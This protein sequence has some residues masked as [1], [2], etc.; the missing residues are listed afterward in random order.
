MPLADHRPQA[1]QAKIPPGAVHL[2]T[3]HRALAETVLMSLA[4]LEAADQFCQIKSVFCHGAPHLGRVGSNLEKVLM[5]CRFTYPNVGFSS[6]YHSFRTFSAMSSV[7]WLAPFA[8]I[9]DC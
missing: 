1:D 5:L 3:A 7:S 9:K 4:A 8:D 2:V 6:A